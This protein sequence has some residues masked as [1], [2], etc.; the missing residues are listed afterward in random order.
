MKRFLSKIPLFPIWPGQIEIDG[1]Q[2]PVKTSPLS[3]Q[4][5]RRLMKG[6]YETAERELVHAFIRPGDHILEIGAS[7]GILTCFLSQKAGNQARIVSVE[8]NAS[9]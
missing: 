4:M 7:I 2:I 6:L 5:R 8:P 3:P 9:Q 1:V